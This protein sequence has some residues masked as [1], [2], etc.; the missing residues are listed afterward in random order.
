MIMTHSSSCLDQNCR[1]QTVQCIDEER[2]E[3]DGRMGRPLPGREIGF[4]GRE[5]GERRKHIGLSL[6][7]EE[8]LGVL[9]GGI[10][11]SF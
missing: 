9:F 8:S 3:A 10:V 4:G 1:E 2:G 7:F 11:G 5:H 6:F